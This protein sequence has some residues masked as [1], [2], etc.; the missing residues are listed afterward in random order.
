MTNEQLQLSFSEEKKLL[1]KHILKIRNGLSKTEREEK[2]EIIRQKLYQMPVYQKADVILAYVDYQ[3]EVITTPLIERA[4]AEGKEVYCPTVQG[5]EMDFYRILGLNELREGY[6]GIWEP[7]PEPERKFEPEKMALG[8]DIADTENQIAGMQQILMLMP[9]A[10]FDK[11]RHRIGYGKG[12][13]DR[14]LNKVA[15]GNKK[16]VA[17]KQ[18]EFPDIC[19]IAL[20]FSCQIVKEVPAEEHDIRPEMIL[21]EEQI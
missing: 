17:S 6:K 5:E 2:S 1:R 14:Y 10:V 12:F 9:G 20:A 11:E 3:S 4:L 16:V 8:T 7:L 13:Y 15:E 19:I 21:T 18:M